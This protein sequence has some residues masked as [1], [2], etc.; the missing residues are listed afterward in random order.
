MVKKDYEDL[1]DW[2]S[3]VNFGLIQKDFF[4]LTQAGTGQWFLQDPKFLQWLTGP[5]QL[6]WCPGD[7]KRR[8]ECVPVATH[9]L[10]SFGLTCKR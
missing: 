10:V 2:I 4:S 6:L 7:R 1:L 9:R 3:A 5:K 8:P